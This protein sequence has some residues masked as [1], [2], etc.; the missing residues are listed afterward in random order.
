MLKKRFIFAVHDKL[1]VQE[2]DVVVMQ[3]RNVMQVLKVGYI[4]LSRHTKPAKPARLAELAEQED[5]AP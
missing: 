1:V 5:P 2:W 4:L 3:V